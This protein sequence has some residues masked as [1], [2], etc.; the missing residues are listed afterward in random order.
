MEDIVGRRWMEKGFFPRKEIALRFE[1]QS[2]R[3][4]TR[5][6]LQQETLQIR[7]KEPTGD[8]LVTLHG[9]EDVFAVLFYCVFGCTSRFTFDLSTHP[10]LSYARGEETMTKSIHDTHRSWD[11]IASR[12]TLRA[13]PTMHRRDASKAVRLLA[14]DDSHP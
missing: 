4:S 9:R 14:S 7:T 10:L 2:R 5:R 1:R 6:W 3:C 13:T 11:E 12:T 8:D